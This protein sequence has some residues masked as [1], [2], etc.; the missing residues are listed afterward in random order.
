MNVK[1]DRKNL[2]LKKYIFISFRLG[3]FYHVY[4]VEQKV[5]IQKSC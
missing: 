5:T 3:L 2:L 1:D 4:I